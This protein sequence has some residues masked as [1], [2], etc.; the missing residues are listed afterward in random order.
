MKKKEIKIQR[1]LSPEESSIRSEL[2]KLFSSCPIPENEFLS[3]L[4]LFM[5]RQDVSRLLFLNELY[6]KILGTHGVIIEFGSRWGRHLAIFE[7]L[8]GIYEPYNYNRTIVGFDT[9]R[10]FP[11]V[12]KK[13]GESSTIAPGSYAVTD[14]YEEYLKKILAYHEAEN[15]LSH[16]KKYEIRKGDA[17]GEIIKYLK[18][19]PETIIALA[20]FDF[21]LY[22]PTKKCL[23]AIKPYLTRGS[24]IVFD[25]LN[26]PDFPGETLAVKEALGFGKYK[27]KHSRYSTV[28]AYVVID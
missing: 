12:H 9:F 24:V 28:Q 25:E 7:A 16:I 6:Q 11:S 18:E 13:D 1:Y 3:N 26:H 23:D 21:D 20:Y 27:I 8:R 15:P 22:Q 5:K 2:W 17:S 19:H 10:G 4:N 14:N